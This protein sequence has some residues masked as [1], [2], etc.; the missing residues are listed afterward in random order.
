MK[1]YFGAEPLIDWRNA[2]NAIRSG[3]QKVF[4]YDSV[5]EQVGAT[6]LPGLTEQRTSERESIFEIIRSI[7]AWHVREGVLVGSRKRGREQKRVDV[8]LAVDMLSHAF[9]KNM[10]RAI[11][12]SG[13]DDFTPLVE[14]LIRHGTYVIVRSDRVGPRHLKNAADSSQRLGLEFYW[15]LAPEGFRSE[16]P[17]L[18]CASIV[19]PD[20]GTRIAVG[21]T[22]AGLAAQII[23]FDGSLHFCTPNSDGVR[24]SHVRARTLTTLHGYLKHDF[25]NK[26]LLPDRWDESH[27]R[28][29][30]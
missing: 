17:I 28:R 15:Q 26:D 20:G 11:L 14:E 3:A 18:D 5:D 25:D 10:D 12:I 30:D 16:N 19:A 1:Q 2:E 8:L 27:Q 24:L 9:N 7:P 29:A 6:D 23:D 13:D 21:I 22:R 4:Y